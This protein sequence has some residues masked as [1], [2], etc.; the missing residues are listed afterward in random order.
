M[1]ASKKTPAQLKQE[2]RHFWQ[3]VTRDAVLFSVG[4]ILFIYEAV[5]RK[6]DPRESILIMEAGMMGLGAVFRAEEFRRRNG[7]DSESDLD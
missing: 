2:R 3:K 1:T 4:L 5:I 6:G 7:G